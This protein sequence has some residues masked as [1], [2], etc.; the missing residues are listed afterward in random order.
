[1]T[2]V[3]KTPTLQLVNGRTARLCRRLT[4]GIYELEDRFVHP[5]A[6]KRAWKSGGEGAIPSLFRDQKPVKQRRRAGGHKRALRLVMTRDLARVRR[7]LLAKQA[8]GG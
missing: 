6:F 1:L 2:A 7:E 4:H 3:A 5:R 8:T